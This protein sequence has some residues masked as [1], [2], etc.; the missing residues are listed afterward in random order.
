[1]CRVS[2]RITTICIVPLPDA[3]EKCQSLQVLP[4]QIGRTPAGRV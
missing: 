2:Q 3:G 4:V 1:M